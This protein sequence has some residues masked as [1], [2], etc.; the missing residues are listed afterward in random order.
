MAR[1]AKQCS[2]FICPLVSL[3]AVLAM[4][5][6]GASIARAGGDNE[7]SPGARAESGGVGIRTATANQ[8]RQYLAEDRAMV[9]AVAGK[10]DPFKVPPPPSLDAGGDGM[11]GPLPPGVR[12]LVI[13]Q[14]RLKGIVRDEET[15]TMI[16]VVTNRANLAYFLHIH[17]QVYNGQVSRITPDAIYSQEKRLDSGGRTDVREVVLKL[18]SELQ[19][20]R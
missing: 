19:E 17:E 11:E 12:G 15:E 13:G 6:A 20:G 8:A 3:A 7:G 18:G 1:N 10:R 4:S 2:Y 5:L 9:N 14:L 16:A